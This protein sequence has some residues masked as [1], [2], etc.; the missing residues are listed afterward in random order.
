MQNSSNWLPLNHSSFQRQYGSISW[1]RCYGR[2]G[3]YKTYIVII[4]VYYFV[5]SFNIG[6]FF[7]HNYNNVS[8][9][10]FNPLMSS[11]QNEKD[12]KE[13]NI[14][15]LNDTLDHNIIR[16]LKSAKITSLPEDVVRQL[17]SWEEIK[18]MYGDKPIIYGLETCQR[19]REMVKPEDRTIGPAGLFNTG[20][21]LSV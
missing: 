20:K 3:C 17:P 9:A 6:I 1:R 21:P 5:A 13:L 10:N 7:T 16:V 8:H 2:V 15:H 11:F 14:T 19:Y 4:F 12:N 18:S